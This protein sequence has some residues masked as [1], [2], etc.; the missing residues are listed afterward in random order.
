MSVYGR[1]LKVGKKSTLLWINGQQIRLDFA[2]KHKIG[3]IIDKNDNLITECKEIYNRKQNEEHFERL[4]KKF[5]YLKKI[6]R[7]FE[8]KGF[9]EVATPKLKDS[10]LQEENISLMKTPYGYLTPSPEV[11]IKKLISVGFDKVFE[12]CFAYRNDEI[13][14]LHKREFLI[15]EWYRPLETHKE[16]I[17]DF[18][19]LIKYL[20]AKSSLD[21]L[22]RHI[23][24]EKIEYVEYKTLFERFVGI[25]IENFDSLQAKRDF[26][27]EGD[28]NKPDILDAVFS[29]KI[30]KNLGLEHPVVV[31]NFP[32]ERAALAKIENGYAKRFETYIA[33][34]ELANCYDEENSYENIESRFTNS[35][36]E[37]FKAVKIGIPAMSGI[38]VGVERLI[39]LL[40]NDTA[41]F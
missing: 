2:S 23:D 17:G 16:I 10:V 4:K 28:V 26:N 9:L 5:D 33:G 27:I 20:N 29:L 35:D 38:A 21:Y 40:E 37:F 32:K 12:L 25:D 30:E 18:I 7:F 22:D 31:Y 11:E 3:D 41:V 15:L 39:M 8:Q 14:S 1:I 19:E 24:L 34:V 13:N 6:R 36:K